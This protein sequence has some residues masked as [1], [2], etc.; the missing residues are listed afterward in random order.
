MFG[1]QFSKIKPEKVLK[2]LKD[3]EQSCLGEKSISP[4]NFN[5]LNEE[6]SISTV[7]H[8]GKRNVRHKKDGKH[9]IWQGLDG[10]EHDLGLF[11]QLEISRTGPGYHKSCSQSLGGEAVADTD[12]MRLPFSKKQVTIVK[13]H[14]GTEGV[15]PN[16][17]IAL[18]NAALKMHLRAQFEKANKRNI[19]CSFYGN[20]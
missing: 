2:K 18:R 14:D 10:Q 11:D 16:Y 9:L 4:E 1:F 3:F 15:G 19:W 6:L 20:C 7:L 13:M 12:T 8:I 5:E 17:R